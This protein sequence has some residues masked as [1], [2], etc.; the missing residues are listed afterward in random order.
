VGIPRQ[1]RAILRGLL[2][3][4]ALGLPRP[5]A[6]VLF[7]VTSDPSYHTNAPAGVF[8]NSGWQFEGRFGAF[9]GTP[10]D[11]HWFVTAWH[12]FTFSLVST[13][14]PFILD[15]TN[16]T[17]LSYVHD[18]SPNSDLVL[19]RVAERLPRYAPIYTGTNETGGTLAVFGRGT[20]RGTA[21]VTAGATNGWLW[22]ASD[23]VMRWGSNRVEAIVSGG[24]APYLYATLDHDAG[25]DEC[26]LS[27]GDS[28][29]AAFLLADGN[30]QL[31][32]I[33][34]AV[35]GPFNTT[36]TGGGF[37]AAIYDEYGLYT[38]PGSNW[39]LVTNHLN[40][41]FV[42]SRISAH[43]A[44]F[45]NTIPDFDSDANGLPDWWEQQY[46]GSIHGLSATNDADVDG[47]SNLAEWIARTD[48]TNPASWFRM[49]A[50]A[51]TGDVATLTFTGWANRLYNV[52]R[53]EAPLTNGT[54]I[55]ATTN[56]FPGANGP[57]AWTDTN[58]LLSATSRFYRIEALLPP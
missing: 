19:C 28:G 55:L 22:G 30:W 11:P 54:W 26:H 4:L 20:R 18:P 12:L 58:A 31:A 14:T 9:L 10:V 35:D 17:V 41:G 15:G 52:Y 47:M 7:D 16:Y 2:L 53:H 40:S 8:T 57:T 42:S 50:L 29:G 46:S 48:P 33:H 3:G 23:N 1:L 37:D 45:T 13:N 5:A 36:N 51:C 21:V 6:G 34:Y 49:D 39:E 25:P 27:G 44:W 56:T 43:Y 24:S 38:K 32:G